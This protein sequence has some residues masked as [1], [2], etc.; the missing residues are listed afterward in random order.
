G[1]R[2]RL[3]L[4]A[5]QPMN[6]ASTMKLVT[7]LAALELLGPAYT[8]KTAA[9]SAAP[10]DNGVLAGDLVIRGSAD[11]RLTFEQF[12]LLLRQLRARGVREIAGDLVLDRSLLAATDPEPSNFDDKPLRPYNVGPD[13]LLLNFKAIRLQLVPDT[14][15]KTVQVTAEPEPA[16]LDITNLI[17]LGN[18]GCGDWKESLRADLNQHGN[19]WR[20]ALT[21]TYSASCGE[22]NW[23]LG[24]L[25]HGEYVR[26]V[27]EQLWRELGG[28]LKGGVRDG[29]VPADARQLATI[30]SAALSEIIR[31]INKFSNNVMARQLFLT[32]GA[33]A[34]ARPARTE[35]ADAAVR[36]WLDGR[37]LRFPELVLDNGSGLSRRERI[38]AAN[39]T[40]LLAAAW[41]SPVMPEFVA[42]LPLTAVDGTMKKRLNGNG[43]AGQAHIKTGTLEGVKTIAGYVLDRKGRQQIV[44]F[45]VNHANAQAAQAAQDALLAWVYEGGR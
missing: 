13:A 38:S 32:I 25:P 34:G 21:G 14:A 37:D 12:W 15:K 44:V 41:K 7:T 4:N 9:W 40:R 36:A 17:R 24:L 2:P 22:K 27:F 29:A 26:G 3:T 6:P 10:I 31:D 35:D 5:D 19:H 33:E 1:V 23:H 45:L 28:T 16:N 30:E 8:W 43:I 39:L 20:L 18:N 11:P 42:S